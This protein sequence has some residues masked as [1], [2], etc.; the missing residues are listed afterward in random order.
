M[1]NWNNSNIHL[2]LFQFLQLDV[3]KQAPMGKLINAKKTFSFWH[4]LNYPTPPPIQT[5]W[6]S[7]FWTSKTI[8]IF[9]AEHCEEPGAAGGSRLASEHPGNPRRREEGAHLYWTSCKKRHFRKEILANW[10]LYI[11]PLS[12][13]V[14]IYIIYSLFH[15]HHC[16]KSKYVIS[17]L[18]LHLTWELEGVH[19]PPFSSFFLPCEVEQ[20]N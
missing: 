10:F 18:F 2:I 12:N 9:F 19:W 1:R 11:C 14:S 13:L 7:C 20:R 6:S 4:C 8:A 15:W 3:A 17:K 5:T 16:C